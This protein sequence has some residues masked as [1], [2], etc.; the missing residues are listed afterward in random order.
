MDA[1]A[2][3]GGVLAIEGPAGAGKTALLEVA[4]TQAIAAGAE[5]RRA[6]ATELERDFAFGGAR[7]LLSA[8]TDV[9]ALDSAARVVAP[10]VAANADALAPPPAFAVLD[11]LTTLLTAMAARCTVV[12]LIDDAHWLDAPTMRWLDYLRVR[13]TELRVLVVITVREAVGRQLP[14]P[15]QVVL[16][17]PRLELW[18][19]APLSETAIA[20]LLQQRLGEP[21]TPALVA[22]C[23]RATAGNAFAVSEL[24]ASLQF[25]GEDQSDLAAR[26]TRRIPG[27]IARSIRARL[28]RL[29][30]DAINLAGAL[31]VLG[32]SAPQHR[33][34]ALARLPPRR[35]SVMADQLA[36]ADLIVA[37]RPLAFVHAL[38]RTAIE[39]DLPLATLSQLHADAA[40]LLADEGSDPEAV[41]AHLLRS[42]PAGDARTAQRLRAAATLALRR[43]APDTAMTYLR[44]AEAEPPPAEDRAAVQHELGRAELL[45]RAPGGVGRLRDALSR[46]G[47]PVTRARIGIDLF[48]GMTFSGDLQGAVQLVRRL[49]DELAQR[50]P[51]LALGLEMRAAVGLIE[52]DCGPGDAELRHVETLARNDPGARA[53]LLLV[54][55]VLALHGDR[56]DDVPTLV[57][58]GLQGDRFLMQHS[59]DSMFAVH[60]VDALVFVDSLPAAA[61]LADKIYADA[62]RRGIVLGGV[63]GATHRG[64]VALRA[65][66]LAEAERVLRDAL[67]TA[68]EHELTF[69]L[70]FVSAYLAEALAGQGRLDDAATL[71]ASVPEAFLEF[72]NAAAST[73]LFIRGSTHLAQGEHAAAVSDLRACGARLVQMGVRNPLVAPWRSTLAL[74]L[75]QGADEATELIAEELSLARRMGI[76]RGVGTALLARAHLTPGDAAVGVLR[77][78]AAVL[79]GSPAVLERA[80]ALTELGTALRR[81]GQSTEARERL[82]EALDSASRCGAQALAARITTELHLAGARPRGPWLTGVKALTPSELRVARL[83]ACGLTNRQIAAELVI[84]LKTVKHHLGAV[85][86]KLAI[87][88]RTE[89]DPA[90]FVSART[91][92]D[93]F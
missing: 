49:R 1:S 64:L 17:D 58:D 88:T 20:S 89:L 54:A 61:T 63:A 92:S 26:L 45:C 47:D 30:P 25:D 66:Q 82:R 19:L 48:D 32:D 28:S 81:S 22:G 27:S 10:I 6:R 46:A 4:R 8:S 41:A 35:V 76:A 72:G 42:D 39:D 90:L 16:G 91:P 50:D 57:A 67:A 84:T 5:V 87:T 70:P 51:A 12:L 9:A 77:E 71:I 13:L 36:A 74:A 60:A 3:R 37:A 62:Q 21:P 38:V 31:A 18:S 24:I 56:L 14:G 43:G 15:L 52:G 78:A 34:A 53:L 11:G 73:L 86:R 7:Q 55:L 29:D 83:A 69:T 23:A 44:R 93:H 85:Y 2:G 68:R 80:R 65:G 59:G 40:E 79:A 75:G 33:V